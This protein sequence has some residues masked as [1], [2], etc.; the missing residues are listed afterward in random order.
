MYSF[1]E[2]IPHKITKLHIKA[3]TTEKRTI[4]FGTTVFTASLDFLSDQY[5]E[6]SVECAEPT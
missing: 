6:T 4:K 5:T 2:S 3:G 1:L